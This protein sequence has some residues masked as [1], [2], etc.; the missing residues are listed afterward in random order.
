MR[1]SVNLYSIIFVI[2]LIV[3][4]KTTEKKK[5]VSSY[6]F[7][8]IKWDSV[9]ILETKD[10]FSNFISAMDSNLKWLNR[11]KADSVFNYG[12]IS[13]STKDF[14]CT[15]EYFLDELKNTAAIEKKSFRKV[16]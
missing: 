13:F 15:S 12:N 10:R 11:K 2:F 14:I 4:C 9:S 3:S 6:S 16:L 5:T 1:I 8:K 7:N